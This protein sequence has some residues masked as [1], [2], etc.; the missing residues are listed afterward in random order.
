VTYLP[1]AGVCLVL[2]AA[3]AGRAESAAVLAPGRKAALAAALLLLAARTAV[4]ETAWASDEKL[5]ENG[6]LV[7]PESAKNHYNLG[8]V[9][10]WSARWPEAAAAHGEAA[11][12]YPGYWDAWAG[13]GRAE[14]ELGR[15]D[16]ARKSYERALA[17]QPSYENGFFGL[18]QVRERMGD[19]RGALAVYRRGLEKNPRSL[20][21]ALRVAALESHLEDP[22]AGRSWRR[23]LADHPGS[24]PGRLGYAQWLRG[25]GEREASRRE[26]VRILALA[27]RWEPALRELAADGEAAGRFLAAAI[28]RERIFRSTRRSGDLLLLLDAAR[29]SAAYRR[30]FAALRER[31]ERAAPWAFR[32]AED[33]RELDGLNPSASSASAAG[34]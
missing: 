18:G 20:P 30:R 21:I 16:E 6:V 10:A 13:R 1:S 33:R 28:A 11:R 5:F 24:L 7:G 31:F 34:G 15:L 4:R 2:G 25:R 23:V 32:Y 3:L 22:S 19:D 17:A 27:P 8:T 14:A 12:I 26:L 9:R 29:Q